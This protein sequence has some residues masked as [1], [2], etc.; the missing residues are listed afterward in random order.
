MHV[1]VLKQVFGDDGPDTRPTV[2]GLGMTVG[3]FHFGGSAIG[4]ALGDFHT[5]MTLI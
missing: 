4:I 5:R 3:Q 1:D 2:F